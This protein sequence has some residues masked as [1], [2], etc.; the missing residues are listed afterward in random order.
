M[1]FAALGAWVFRD[2]IRQSRLLPY[3]VICALF[4]TIWFFSGV[5]Q[6]IQHLLPVLPLF[7]VVMTVAAE[8]L[9]RRRG[10]RGPLVAAAAAC[11]AIQLAAQGIF[12][13]SY[14]NHLSSGDRE[15]FLERNVPN[16]ASVPWIN[17]NLG[18]RDRI[19]LGERQVLYYLSVPYFFAAPGMQALVDV[20]QGPKD[21]RALYRQLKSVAITHV[22]LQRDDGAEGIR[23]SSP[24]D[25]LRESGC[26]ELLKSVQTSQFASRTLPSLRSRPG[27]QDILKLCGQ[28]CL[29]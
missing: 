4:Y 13:I 19:L 18:P 12:S 21:P 2:R 20:R 11:I 15:V 26:F 7:L 8:R 9:T 16:Y 29:E 17:A 3:A 6:R 10:L 23:Y 22:L 28:E 1:P 27:V 25:A 24:L 5:S 14:L